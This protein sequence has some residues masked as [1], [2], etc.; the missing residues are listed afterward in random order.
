MDSGPAGQQRDDGLIDM[1][2]PAVGAPL[3]S[4]PCLLCLH[5]QCQRAWQS[6]L[7]VSFQVLAVVT[8]DLGI[9]GVGCDL[10]PLALLSL[11]QYSQL[12]DST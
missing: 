7:G 10:L 2:H 3:Y 8:S 9:P 4:L 1:P 12:P 11:A 5:T 6:S